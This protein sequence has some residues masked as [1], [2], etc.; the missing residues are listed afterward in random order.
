LRANAPGALVGLLLLAACQSAPLTQP[1]WPAPADPMGLA[2]Q[3]GLTPDPKEHLVTHTHSHLDVFV[4]GQRILVPSAIG[5]DI[6]AKGIQDKL[7]SD[8]TAHEYYV[9]VG[10]DTPCLS[11]LHTHDPTGIIHTESKVA[12]QEPYTLGQLFTEWGVR[13]DA[14]CVGEFCRANTPIAVYLNGAQQTGN[15]AEI[16]ML[17]HMEI[18]IVIGKAPDSIPDS[19]PFLDPA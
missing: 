1:S 5:I 6:A 16:K 19:Y 7:S 11:P 14:D 3:A 17:S 8:G 4:D 15:P 10:C 9:P 12:G 2:V 13:L 18:V